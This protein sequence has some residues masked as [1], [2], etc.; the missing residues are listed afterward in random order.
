MAALYGCLCGCGIAGV[1]AA[2]R[3]GAARA[4]G[5]ARSRAAVT[6]GM[7]A[8]DGA[9]TPIGALGGCRRPACHAPAAPGV[10]ERGYQ[11]SMG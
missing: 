6:L 5:P 8:G 1:G 7:L 9:A 3:C 11:A 2:G 4:G 10:A